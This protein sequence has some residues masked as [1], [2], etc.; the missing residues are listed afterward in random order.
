MMRNP[1]P[2]Y[3][4]LHQ[5]IK[6]CADHLLEQGQIQ[7]PDSA[8]ILQRLN[9]L[10]E[11]ACKVR[12]DEHYHPL[13]ELKLYL[14]NTMLNY[15]DEQNQFLTIRL[16]EMVSLLGKKTDFK[17]P[18]IGSLTKHFL[19]YFLK[20]VQPGGELFRKLNAIKKI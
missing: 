6:A 12:P 19:D 3:N 20:V 8:S 2:I 4:L 11:F 9:D 5:E 10:L 13:R 18:A 16:S 17:N 14:E 7:T 15:E 1:S